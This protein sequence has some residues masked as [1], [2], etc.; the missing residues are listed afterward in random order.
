MAK[1]LMNEYGI[2]TVGIDHP[3]VVG[4]RI[5]PNVYTTTRELDKFVEALKR[6]AV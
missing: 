5:T 4:C 2:W 1:R 3:P 6:L